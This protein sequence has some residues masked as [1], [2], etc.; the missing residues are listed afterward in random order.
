MGAFDGLGG[1]FLESRQSCMCALRT[2]PLWRIYRRGVALLQCL[3]RQVD[4]CR[5]HIVVIS[6]GALGIRKAIGRFGS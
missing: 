3:V 1:L 6:A 5:L 2:A 4:M